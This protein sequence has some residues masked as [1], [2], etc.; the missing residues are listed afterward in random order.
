MIEE[1]ASM[2]ACAVCADEMAL[3]AN[4]AVFGLFVFTAI[5]ADPGGH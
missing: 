1:Y 5:G 3:F 4:A 2:D